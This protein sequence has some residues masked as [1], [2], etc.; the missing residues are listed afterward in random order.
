GQGGIV[1][2]ALVG[3]GGRQAS[4]HPRR[5]RAGLARTALG[6]DACATACGWISA[7]MVFGSLWFCFEVALCSDSLKINANGSHLQNV[8]INRHARICVE[9][10]RIRPGMP[11]TG[12]CFESMKIRQ[13]AAG[14]AKSPSPKREVT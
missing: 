1:G 3:R 14:R 12:F 7:C 13:T 6:T 11:R 4:A 8:T 5:S 10:S 2:L 9:C